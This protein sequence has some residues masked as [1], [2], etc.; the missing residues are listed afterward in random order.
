MIYTDRTRILLED[1]QDSS[2]GDLM[3]RIYIHILILFVP[4]TPDLM[5]YFMT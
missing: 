1:K 2:L 4:K 3:S 5:F